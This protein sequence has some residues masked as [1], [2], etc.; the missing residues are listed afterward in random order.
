VPC[1]QPQ[2]REEASLPDPGGTRVPRPRRLDDV[3]GQDRVVANLR[4]AVA[5]ARA[6]GD[7]LP[8]VLL[9]GPAG[10]GKTTLARMLAGEMGT[11]CRRVSGPVVREI[12][13]LLGV[14]GSALQALHEPYLIRRGLVRITPMGREL[15]RTH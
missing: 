2:V 3:V 12:G 8:H 7:P 1:P 13:V 11:A 14:T 15:A 10:L 9:Y 5:V 6:T 4:R